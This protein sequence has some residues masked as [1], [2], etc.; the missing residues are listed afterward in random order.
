ME[1]GS[2]SILARNLL[3]TASPKPAHGRA[4]AILTYYCNNTNNQCHPNLEKIAPAVSENSA[5][6]NKKLENSAREAEKHK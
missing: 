2:S 1:L 5:Q 6:V 4:E 3:H